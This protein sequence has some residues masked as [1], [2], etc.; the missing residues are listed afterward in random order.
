MS[1]IFD[2][3][4]HF[5]SIVNTYLLKSFCIKKILL[6]FGFKKILLLTGNEGRR[7]SM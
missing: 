7:G 6:K 1:K 4:H 5:W 3:T 2:M